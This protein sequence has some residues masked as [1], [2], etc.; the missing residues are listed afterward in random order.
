MKVKF[1]KLIVLFIFCLFLS[2][3]HDKK[4]QKYN[5]LEDGTSAIPFNT[6]ENDTNTHQKISITENEMINTNANQ[7]MTFE[8]Y[9]ILKLD[10]LQTGI[11]KPA[12]ICLYKGNLYICDTDKNGIVCFDMDFNQIE[13][14]GSLG[15]E[16]GN[17]T[18]PMDIT[19]A[20]GYFYVLDSGNSRIQKFNSEF[21]FQEEYHLDALSSEQGFGKYQDIE[22]DNLGNIFVSTISADSTD[23][24]IFYLNEKGQNSLGENMIGYMCSNGSQIFFANTLEMYMEENKYIAE[25][26]K[27]SLYRVGASGVKEMA[28]LCEKF[29]PV[30]LT[31][32]DNIIYMISVAFSSVNC[33]TEEGE[34][35]GTVVKL[36]E[37][38]LNMYMVVDADGKI[39]I[40]D[41]DNGIIYKII[42]TNS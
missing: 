9:Q 33:Y 1:Y 36:P 11:L 21:E 18:S 14:F 32:A 25:S 3:C 2:G 12:G 23:A 15:M 26:G 10:K 4:N 20:N 35:L 8:N 37:V 38:S 17:F 28:P 24:H 31:Y 30:A 7:K 27:N 19:F 16:E 41:Y 39:Y 6:S 29:A 40:T 34:I 42:N 22:V 13:T 5:S